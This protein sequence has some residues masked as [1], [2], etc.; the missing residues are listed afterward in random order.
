MGLSR[1]KLQLDTRWKPNRQVPE[2]TATDFHL[3]TAVFFFADVQNTQ[4]SMRHSHQSK[5]LGCLLSSPTRSPAPVGAEEVHCC[6]CCSIL[7]DRAGKTK[8]SPACPKAV[9]RR[10]NDLE[11]LSDTMPLYAITRLARLIAAS[12][13]W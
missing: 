6:H 3:I 2:C 9:Q 11:T 12:P 7:L 5:H 4:T 13:S 8:K 1:R 10:H